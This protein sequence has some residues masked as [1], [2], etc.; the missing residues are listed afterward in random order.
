VSERSVVY[1]DASAIVKLLADEPG[2]AE[3][4]AYLQARPLRVASRIAEVE[5]RRAVARL[6]GMVDHDRLAGVLGA[7][8]IVELAASVA[9]AAGRLSPALL[10]TLDAIHL[11]TALELLPDLEAFV[12]YDQRL[13]EAA[14]AA[15][16]A[17]ASP[18]P[19]LRE[20]RRDI[21]L[22]GV[23][24]RELIEEGRR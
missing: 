5:V 16:I 12:T 1:L 9:L 11:A 20:L 14:T 18:G 19:S 4:A 23:P 13:A 6:G 22:G 24:V 10:R 7:L 3:L 8:T 2:S 21:T 15:G 17:V